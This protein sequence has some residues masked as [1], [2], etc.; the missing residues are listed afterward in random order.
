M[1]TVDE[2]PKL[3]KEG[4]RYM[5]SCVWFFLFT[6]KVRSVRTRA[7]ALP[8]THTHTHSYAWNKKNPYKRTDIPITR[9]E[10]ERGTS[11]AARARACV[12][13]KVSNRMQDRVYAG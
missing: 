10:H 5:Q 7:L 6:S 3:D 13:A 9:A 8:S 2:T 12:H 1:A 11:H 4:I